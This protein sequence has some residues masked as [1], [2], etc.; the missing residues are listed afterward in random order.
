MRDPET[1][2]LLTTSVSAGNLNNQSLV[3]T[4]GGVF[5]AGYSGMSETVFFA[6]ASDLSRLV[7]IGTGGGGLE[8]TTSIAAGAVWIG[9]PTRISCA[10]PSTGH[11][12]AS[13]P[14]PERRDAVVA[15]I[16]SVSFAHGQ[17]FAVY[18]RASTQGLV[19]IH[20]PAKCT[21]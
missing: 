18:T 5:E 14:L 19:R 2:A 4:A 13:A 16:G 21:Q 8:A 10:D 3:A 11:I 9:G 6:A 17:A 12:R 15:D 20:P 7:E 1:G